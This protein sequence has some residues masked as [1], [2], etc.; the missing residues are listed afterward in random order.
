MIFFAALV[1][2]GYKC[3]DFWEA[4][5]NNPGPGVGDWCRFC[6]KSK[7]DNAQ[8]FCIGQAETKPKKAEC[9]DIDGGIRFVFDGPKNSMNFNR[10]LPNVCLGGAYHPQHFQNLATALGYKN[11]K[12][13]DAAA[14]KTQGMLW[15]DE[16][17]ELKKMHYHRPGTWRRV[18]WTPGQY[19]Y[20][21]SFSGT[22]QG[23]FG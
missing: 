3:S 2:G 11:Y 21:I 13:N 15:L 5:I 19:V 6:F 8:E 10:H 22:N 16:N 20:D 4:P 12:V 1:N 17:G 7:F 14:G 9:R 18:V 23:K